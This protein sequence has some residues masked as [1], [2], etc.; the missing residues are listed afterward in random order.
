MKLKNYCFLF[1]CSLWACSESD[2]NVFNPDQLEI[3]QLNSKKYY[4]EQI[5]DPLHIYGYGDF[6][7]VLE[8]RRISFD[9]PLVH[10]LRKNPLTYFNSKGVN[11]YGPLEIPSADMFNQLESDSS[12]LIYSG[13]DRK[14]VEFEIYDSSRLA[15]SEFKMPASNTTLGLAYLLPDS[16]F[17]GIPTFEKNKYLKLDFYGNKIIGY[18]EWEQIEGKEDMSPFHHFTLNDGWFRPD[19]D[20]DLFVKASIFRDRLE[21]FYP[22]SEEIKIIDGPSLELPPF[23]YYQ[24]SDGVNIPISNPFRYRDVYITDK[25]IFAL[26]GGFSHDHYYKTSELARKIFV[27]SR[28]GEPFYNLELDRSI[29]SIVVDQKQRKIFGITT[30]DDPGIAI[31]DLPEELR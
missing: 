30:D 17:F 16:S 21:I 26:Y 11:G 2:Q 3:I 5:I 6:L 28:E 8:D 27:F 12:F 9:L 24:P 1:L 7:V 14:F 29:S 13:I 22:E 20:F 25:F 18:G 19:V 23:E 10:I 31:F 4:F 15:V